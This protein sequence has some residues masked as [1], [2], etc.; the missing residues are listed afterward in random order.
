MLGMLYPYRSSG[1][2]CPCSRQCRR[3]SCR[4]CRPVGGDQGRSADK[5]S[6][7]A[8]LDELR[9][10]SDVDD[11]AYWAYYDIMEAVNPHAR[12]KDDGDEK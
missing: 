1:G 6:I 4:S 3:R 11:T 7:D 5:A 12:R 8:H 2:W 9:Q 10:F